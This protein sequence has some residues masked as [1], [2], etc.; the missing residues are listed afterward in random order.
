MY[1]QSLCAYRAGL[2]GTTLRKLLH[3][4]MAAGIRVFLR[5]LVSAG[6]ISGELAKVV[7]AAG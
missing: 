7:P 2:T 4:A 1:R 5:K 3:L 6:V